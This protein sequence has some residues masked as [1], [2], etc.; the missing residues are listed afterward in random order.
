[1]NL[2]LKVELEQFLNAIGWP[3]NQDLSLELDRIIQTIEALHGQ[4]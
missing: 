4:G 1:M 2:E 3:R